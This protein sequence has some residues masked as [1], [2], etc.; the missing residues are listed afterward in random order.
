M[1]LEQRVSNFVGLATE[2]TETFE[3][4][5]IE[6]RDLHGEA[7]ISSSFWTLPYFGAASTFEA[8]NKKTLPILRYVCFDLGQ[9]GLIKAYTVTARL[10]GGDHDMR[11]RQEMVLGIGGIRALG[12]YDTVFEG[13]AIARVAM[14]SV[15]LVMLVGVGSYEVADTKL[16]RRARPNAVLQLCAY[17]EHVARLQGVWPEEIEV[18]RRASGVPIDF[19]PNFCTRMAI[20]RC[21]LKIPVIAI[22]TL[23]IRITSLA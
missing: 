11:I 18:V 8:S 10:Y 6:L 5:L 16:A 23:E 1:A 14:L 9:G 2:P 3:F 22:Q 13:E 19:P 20:M 15:P 7:A 17:S 4:F 21:E 12:S